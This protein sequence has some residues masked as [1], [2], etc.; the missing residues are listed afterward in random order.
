MAEYI[1]RESL[2]ADGWYLQR[3]INGDGYACVQSM[4]ILDI[5][6]A[7]VVSRDCYDRLLAENDE[8]R[9]E[10]PVRHGRW[11]VTAEFTDCVYAH[12]DQ[13]KITQV[14]FHNKP[15]TNYCP[16]CGARM[17]GDGDG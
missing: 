8:L 4:N 15:L 14:F 7:D 2:A 6:A 11:I 16:N 9:K 12:C 10:R 5:P 3:H 17:D 1:E 13:C